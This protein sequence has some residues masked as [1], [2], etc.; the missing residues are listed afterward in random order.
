MNPILQENFRIASLLCLCSLL[1]RTFSEQLWYRWDLCFKLEGWGDGS[2]AKGVCCTSLRTWVWIPSTSVNAGHC[3]RCAFNPRAVGAE[4]EA[5][6]VPNLLDMVSFKFRERPC[7]KELMQR[8]KDHTQCPSP[9]STCVHR[10][11]HAPEHN[12]VHTLNT[13]K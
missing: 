4:T 3:S 11:A 10:S 13:N 2:M 9:T 5:F 12:C 8:I 1:T 7:L 6:W